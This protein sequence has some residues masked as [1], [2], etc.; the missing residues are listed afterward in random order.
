MINKFKIF[1]LHKEKNE[2]ENDAID[3]EEQTDEE[4]LNT[5]DESLMKNRISLISKVEK[6]IYF[7]PVITLVIY[8]GLFV[9][10]ILMFV[11]GYK[12]EDRDKMLVNVSSVFYAIPTMVR[13]IAFFWVFY[14]FSGRETIN[15]ELKMI[16]R[17]MLCRGREFK[18]HNVNI[19]E[20]I[21]EGLE[22]E[23][24]DNENSS[25]SEEEY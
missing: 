23:R 9:H 21:H 24:K 18:K 25:E 20:V 7:Y 4:E 16:G 19:N 15:N 14:L 13:G 8:L 22:Y 17:C 2:K 12:R 11:A 3:K 5:S 6:H 1:T 10:R